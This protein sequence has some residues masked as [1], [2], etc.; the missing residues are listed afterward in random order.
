MKAPPLSDLRV[1]PSSADSA[2]SAFSEQGLALLVVL[3][4]TTLLMALG[5]GLVLLT[6][7]ESR[8]AAHFGAGLQALY[9]AEAAIERVLP[10][11][12]A[13]GDWDAIAA[14]AV[15][16]TFVDGDPSG[17]RSGPDGTAV[18]LIAATSIE[19]CGRLSCS[20]EEAG[21]LWRLYA[22][23]PLR[24]LRP[25][26]RAGSGI[27]VIVWAAEPA[28]GNAADTLVLRARAYG[29][30]GVRRTV[31]AAVTRRGSGVRLLSWR[32]L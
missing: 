9:A 23:A 5:A 28:G 21:V 6:T 20:D 3:M 12:A 14:G 25:P 8:I 16:S 7:T 32:E 19:R 31:E 24:D 2:P 26:V 4:T 22:H 10:D 18:D 30:Y 29:F 17:I 27:Y 11:L 15:R 1:V 13:T